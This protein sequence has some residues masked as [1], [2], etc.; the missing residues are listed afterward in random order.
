M[1]NKTL[2]ILI[3][4]LGII[5][6]YGVYKIT[7][8]FS[9]KTI[10]EQEIRKGIILEDMKTGWFISERALNKIKI[11]PFVEFRVKNSL[12][13]VISKGSIN[14]LITFKIVGDKITFDSGWAIY[15]K[16][17][18]KIGNTGEKVKIWCIHGYVGKS[19]EAFEKNK[20]V[21][22]KLEATIFIKYKGSKFIKLKKVDIAQKIY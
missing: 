3:L 10:S 8:G 18:I 12:K 1:N 20:N 2:W 4:I 15:P 9:F 21:W 14:F 7:G 5:I 22:K 13:E 19:A 16:K 6:F 17:D 11:L